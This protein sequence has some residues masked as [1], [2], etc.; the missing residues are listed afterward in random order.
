MH[1]ST[2]VGTSQVQQREKVPSMT[3]IGGAPPAEHRP[4][5]TRVHYMRAMIDALQA[6]GGSGRPGYVYAWLTDNGLRR[7]QKAPEGIDPERHYERE[8]RFARQELADGGLIVS[9]DHIW[10]L[11]AQSEGGL[12]SAEARRIIRENRLR[13][14]SDLARPEVEIATSPLP[15]ARTRELVERPT[16]GPRPTLWES[17]IVRVEGPASTYVFQF[18]G[19]DLWKVGFASDLD[20]RL[21]TINRHVPV[22]VVGRRWVKVLSR[23]WPSQEWAYAM[24][25]EL[26]KRLAVNR[27]MFERVQCPQDLLEAA[28]N[29][30]EAAIEELST[31]DPAAPNL[32]PEVSP[33]DLP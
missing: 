28:W 20:E 27:T 32:L 3:D 7:P 15:I 16:T 11:T 22:E 33:R 9:K 29:Q 24:E 10:V 23:Y 5:S 31:H 18:Q 4:D 17:M 25:Q 13:R 14:D 26:L 6:N 8:V 19:S 1:P 2:E 30:A 21:S 12:T